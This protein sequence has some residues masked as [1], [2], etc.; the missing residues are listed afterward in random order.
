[1]AQ[2]ISAAVLT[3]GLRNTFAD[4]YQITYDARIARLGK[5]M[6]LGVPSD[7]KEEIYAYF[8][9]APYPKRWPRGRNIS[10]KPFDS[11]DFSV[12]NYDFGRRIEWHENDR[13]DDQTQSL[14]GQ[15]KAL[16]KHFATLHE[17]IFFQMLLA[18]ANLDLLP[19]IPNCPDGVALYSATDGKSAA[20]FGISGGNIITGSTVANPAFIQ[21]DVL[22]AIE[23]FKQFQDTEGEPLWDEAMLDGGGYVLIYNVANDANVRRALKASTYLDRVT[24]AGSSTSNTGHASAATPAN[25]VVEEGLNIELWPTQRITTDDLYIFAAGCDHK[26][27]FQQERKALRE[28]VATMDNSDHVRDTKEEYLQYDARYGYGA[29]LP[30]QTIQ[31]NN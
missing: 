20:R 12:I 3:A 18:S 14:F 10:S 26:A 28:S 11:V 25:I 7:K 21:D 19:A 17:R 30:Y 6:E 9:S 5:V 15:A 4:A 8:E 2:V 13:E 16:G 23:R 1:M 22:N 24:V 29:F 31:I 27:V